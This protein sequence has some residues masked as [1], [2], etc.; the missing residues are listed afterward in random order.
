[1]NFINCLLDVTD[2]ALTWDI[3]ED[4]FT[5]AVKIQACRMAGIHPEDMRQSP[6]D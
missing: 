2:E 6:S 1:M 3:P 5:D 4:G